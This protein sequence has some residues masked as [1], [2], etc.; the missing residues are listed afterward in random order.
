[1]MAS[2]R[3]RVD[4]KGGKILLSDREDWLDRDN[5]H[6]GPYHLLAIIGVW[7]S[8]CFKLFALV[9]LC[10]SDMANVKGKKTWSTALAKVF[11]CAFYS[12]L[13]VTKELDLPS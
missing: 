4:R 10:F 6:F 5:S 2:K 8:K 13:T 9:D 1:M 11:I 3:I 12:T 7:G